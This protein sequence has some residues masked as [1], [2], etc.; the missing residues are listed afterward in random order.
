MKKLMPSKLVQ[1]DLVQYREFP[2]K[3]LHESGMSGL[4]LSKP[5]RGHTL[6]ENYEA[7]TMVDVLWDRPRS[8]AWG[9]KH[10][11]EEYIDEIEAITW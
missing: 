6:W 10:I 8:P 3:E 2:H 9:E 1:G 11:C 7:A 5:Y 4:V